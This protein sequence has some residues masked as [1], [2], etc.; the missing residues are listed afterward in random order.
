MHSFDFL[1]MLSE[2][3]K[4]LEVTLLDF[5]IEIVHSFDL[6]AMLSEEVEIL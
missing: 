4:I 1:A 3:T 6:L 5:L 2:E